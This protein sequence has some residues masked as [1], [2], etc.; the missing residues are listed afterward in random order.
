MA[1]NQQVRRPW[2]KRRKVVT[3]A[4]AALLLAE[5]LII[6]RAVQGVEIRSLLGGGVV[7]FLALWMSSLVAL[8]SQPGLE[9]ESISQT[10]ELVRQAEVNLEEGLRSDRTVDAMEDGGESSRLLGLS[11]LWTVTH[12]RLDHYHGIALEQAAKSFRNAQVAMVLGFVL[13]V[14]FAVAGLTAATTAGAVV[15]GTLGAVSAAL[16]G[17][18]SKTFIRSQE[19]AAEHLRAY[20]AQPLEFS[21]YLA[22]ERLVADAHLEG[23]DRAQIISSLVQGMIAGSPQN[24]PPPE[25][26]GTQPS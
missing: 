20:F 24:Q 23:P 11:D 22:A 5:T 4:V 2:S 25:A 7:I 15:A 26:A 18:V 19:S 21:R 12:R 3:F 17:Y 1:E 8:I 6:V 14:A 16:A 9:V 10:R 13:L